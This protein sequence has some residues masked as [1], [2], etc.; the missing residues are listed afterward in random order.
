[1]ARYL[2]S[3]VGRFRL[4]RSQTG[5]RGSAAAI[6]HAPE[7]DC[8]RGV[9]APRVLREAEQRSQ[10]TGVGA[11]QVLIQHGVIAEQAYLERLSRH[12]GIAREDFAAIVRDDC[13]LSDDQLAYAAQHDMLPARIR[14][15]PCYI[16]TPRGLTA[17]RLSRLAARFPG[18]C[19]RIRLASREDLRRFLMR[20]TGNV[21]ADEAADGLRRHAPEMSA[22]PSTRPRRSM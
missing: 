11:D 10:A 21:L 4:P 7:L 22:A 6:A 8:L 20:Q 18:A 15:E 9:L 14:G 5:H 19:R 2:A 12:T 1:M 16:C 3:A 17:R 13:P